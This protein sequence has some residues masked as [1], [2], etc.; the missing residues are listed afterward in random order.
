MPARHF[1]LAAICCFT[2]TLA[3]E[4]HAQR[5]VLV[6]PQKDDPVLTDA[7]NR[8]G[9]ELE[10]HRFEA[11]IVD[12]DIGPSPSEALAEIAKSTGALASIAFIHQSDR[13]SVQLWLADRV[14]GKTTMRSIDVGSG[15]DTS[16]VLAIR[17]VDLLRASLQEF[18]PGERPP[19]DVAGVDPAPV[20][21][22]V[23]ELAAE[24][25][26]GFLL[27]AGALSLIE[28]GSFGFAFG[29]TLG[30]FHRSGI[31]EL[32]LGGA[33]PLV[34]A[35]YETPNGSAT[36]RQ[37]LVWGE[38]RLRVLDSPAFDVDASIGLGAHFMQADGQAVPPLVSRSDDLWTG[39]A[40]LG[41][42]GELSLFARVAMGIGARAVGLWPPVGV[43]VDRQSAVMSPVVLEASATLAVG[44]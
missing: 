9:A 37:E 29:P 27:R 13:T 21:L 35:R 19:P 33:G 7:F 16:S 38:G 10:L 22:A 14:S 42:H 15:P 12:R 43:A 44:L 1:A 20:P 25:D 31:L 24:P 4:V 2:V 26:D 28:G 3:A 6:R 11:E 23:T 5:V 40:A 8:L 30:I 18:E 41:A 32:G 36:I 34:G 17:A 39:F